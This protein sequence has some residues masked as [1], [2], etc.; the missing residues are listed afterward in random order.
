MKPI[1]LKF[2][3]WYLLTD[4]V[5]TGVTLGYGRAYKHHD[6]PDE[7]MIKKSIHDAIMS[8]ICEIL[9]VETNMK[10]T[11]ALSSAVANGV[12]YGYRRV[13]SS[14][15]EDCSL[16]PSIVKNRTGLQEESLRISIYDAVM[17]ALGQVVDFD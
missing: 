2:N 11:N 14:D 6:N 1:K 15:I 10:I 17:E 12:A 13:E 8:N 16:P 4:N 5:E 9:A 7:D 3:A